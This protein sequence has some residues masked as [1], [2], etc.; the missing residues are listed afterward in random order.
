[1]RGASARPRSTSFSWDS[2][3]PRAGMRN[4]MKGPDTGPSGKSA[5]L[6]K[7]PSYD[8][9]VADEDKTN[10]RLADLVRT[11]PSCIHSQL[12]HLVGALTAAPPCCELTPHAPCTEQIWEE[13]GDELL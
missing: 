9:E 3:T 7:T 6:T 5:K 4:S 12:L 8:G 11:G 2:R 10:V 1:L 13:S